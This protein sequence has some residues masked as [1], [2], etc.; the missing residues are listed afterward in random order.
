[1]KE[2]LI[3]FENGNTE[4][5][6]RWSLH[7]IP[8]PHM[9]HLTNRPIAIIDPDMQDEIVSALSVSDAYKRFVGWSKEANDRRRYKNHDRTEHAIEGDDIFG[10]RGVITAVEY[11]HG[12]KQKSGK[13][14]VTISP[15]HSDDDFGA[16]PGNDITITFKNKGE[17]K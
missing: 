17:S 6:K 13:I 16:G 2:Y 7:D 11:N 1:M 15:K 8:L 10:G 9:E 5:F 4:K 3:I 14:V 12:E